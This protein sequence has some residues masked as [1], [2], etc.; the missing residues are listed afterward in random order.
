MSLIVD[1]SDCAVSAITCDITHE[2]VKFEFHELL[3]IVQKILIKSLFIC[4]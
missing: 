1:H 2:M 3:H 4:C